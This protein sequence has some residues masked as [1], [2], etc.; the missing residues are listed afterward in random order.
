MRKLAVLCA[1]AG[2]GLSGCAT[3]VIGTMTLSQMSSVVG[4]LSTVA[5]GKDLNE[6]ILSA[7]MDQ[8]CRITEGLMRA[9]REICEAWGSPATKDDFQGLLIAGYDAEGNVVRTAPLYMR[10]GSYDYDTGDGIDYDAIG[11]DIAQAQAEQY[12]A[13][14]TRVALRNEQL[15]Y[16]LAAV[17]LR[18]ETAG[19]RPVPGTLMTVSGPITPRPAAFADVALPKPKPAALAEVPLPRAKPAAL[20]VVPLPRA[21]PE[22]RLAAR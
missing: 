12:A 21:K 20:A 1:V 4:V 10:H 22:L 18:P 14:E 16:A 13:A 11:R 3:Q 6:H 9:D 5:T 8:D 15:R 17:Y 7:M 2:L 19:E